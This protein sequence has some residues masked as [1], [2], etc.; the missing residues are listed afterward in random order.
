MS[1]AYFKLKNKIDTS[2]SVKK[3]FFLRWS[4]LTPNPD[5]FEN[6]GGIE[7]KKISFPNMVAII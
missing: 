3:N 1:K 4:L 5:R 2:Y 7:K 6:R